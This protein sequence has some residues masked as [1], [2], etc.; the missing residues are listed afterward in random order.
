MTI[1]IFYENILSIFN[2]HIIKYDPCISKSME[3][4]NSYYN[5]LKYL[6]RRVT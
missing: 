3:I 6:K 1:S 2:I 5:Y 4:I